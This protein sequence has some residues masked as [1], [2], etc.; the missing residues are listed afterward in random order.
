MTHPAATS[1]EASRSRPVTTSRELTDEPRQSLIRRRVP[2]LFSVRFGITAWY[3]GVLILTIA[4]VGIGFRMLL[5]RSLDA[6]GQEQ[7]QDAAQEIRRNIEVQTYFGAYDIHIDPD[8]DPTSLQRS[9]VSFSIYDTSSAMPLL[10]A[11]SYAD[12]WPPNDALPDLFALTEEQHGSV[13]IN[14][15]P[16]RTLAYPITSQSMRYADTGEPVV[17][18]M[19]F[20]AESLQFNTRML[21][22]M[23][24]LL[25]VSGVFG[26]G[27][28]SI[29]GWLL[30]GRAL[31]PVN[32]IMSSAE[33]IANDRSAASL[34]RR[35][36]VPAT[37]DEIAQL[38][39]TFNDMLDRIEQAFAAQRR[40]VADASHELRTPLTSIKGNIDVLRRQLAAGRPLAPDD[41][42]DAL[43]DVGRESARMGRLVEDLLALARNES[44]GYA[45]SAGMQVNSLDVLAG[46]AFR[47]GSC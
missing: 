28:A 6:R 40:F 45:G 33:D 3:A 17:I 37:G 1:P 22:Q 27:V 36:E 26:A 25:A 12:M 24:K 34:S 47:W 2:F 11:G 38:A 35:V 13:S 41:I 46:E 10:R 21:E 19:I 20:A 39:E 14:E 7:L 16:M 31:A 30:A 5:V 8:F 9:G 44:G 15:Y 32:R 4:I 43:G 42:V 18:G 29:G 23:N